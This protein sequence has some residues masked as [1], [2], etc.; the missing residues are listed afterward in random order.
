MKAVPVNEVAEAS[1]GVWPVP[2]AIGIL[3]L[4]KVS[5][6]IRATGEAPFMESIE[7]AGEIPIPS[8]VKARRVR[9]G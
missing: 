5:A 1:I 4:M 6:R 9:G 3:V 8:L 7:G 2:V